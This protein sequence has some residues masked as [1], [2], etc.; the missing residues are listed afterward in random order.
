M[1][2]IQRA[3]ATIVAYFVPILISCVSY[4]FTFFP[5]G[6]QF[7]FQL[8]ILLSVYWILYY[9]SV[10]LEKKR[11]RF[12]RIGTVLKHSLQ[13]LFVVM[14][15]LFAVVMMI[16][17]SNHQSDND[18]PEDVA[19]VVV[20]GCGLTGEQPQEML[21]KRLIAARDFLQ[22]HPE[23]C[24]VLCGGK[25]PRE[26]ITEAEA[27]RRW[28]EREG[29]DGSRL[30]LEEKSTDTRENLRFASEIIRKEFPN[31]SEVVI[32]ST[33]F[34]LFRAKRLASGE[35]HVPYGISA[36]LPRNPLIKINYYLREF[37]SI[38]IMY[39][40]EIFA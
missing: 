22:E 2:T 5:T 16:V 28:L 33:G 35:G 1:N 14:A 17:F 4:V 26:S 15:V 9:T 36:E 25:G 37:A 38:L 13:V 39:G 10:L 20:L 21:E 30:R 8:I 7:T 40:E 24:A 34:H 3:R 11:G 6:I 12:F 29:V 27:M 18:I 32:V 31:Q 19:V 23:A